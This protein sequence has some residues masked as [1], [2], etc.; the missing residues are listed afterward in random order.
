MNKKFQ[1][2][3]MFHDVVLRIPPRP[4]ESY[5]VCKNVMIE[6]VYFEH[7]V[8]IHPCVIASVG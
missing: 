5:I 8:L 1:E 7:M 3:Q 4:R 2:F 6:H